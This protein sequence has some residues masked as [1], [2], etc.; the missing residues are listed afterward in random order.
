MSTFGAKAFIQ[1]VREIEDLNHENERLKEENTSLLEK[2]DQNMVCVNLMK[3][4]HDSLSK[5]SLKKCEEIQEL[6]DELM[7]FKKMIDYLPNDMDDKWWDDE[8]ERW[9]WEDDDASADETDEEESE[10]ESEEEES[11]EE[12][13]Y[14][15]P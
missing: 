3:A 7:K 1:R 5:F 9:R 2:W 10:E 4:S 12:E 11:E 14:P 8:K 13:D 15:S 6:K